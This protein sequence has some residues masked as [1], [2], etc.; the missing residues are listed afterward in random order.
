LDELLGQPHLQKRQQEG[1]G[2]LGTLVLVYA[3]GMEAVAA[4]LDR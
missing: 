1:Q 3:I 2:R 4:A